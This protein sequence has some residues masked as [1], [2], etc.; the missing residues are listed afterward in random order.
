[1]KLIPLPFQED[2][3]IIPALPKALRRRFVGCRVIMP[4]YSE[5]G[6]NIGTRCLYRKSERS[7]FVASAVCGV[8]ELKNDGVIYYFWITSITSNAP[9]CTAFYDDAERYAFLP[10]RF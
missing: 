7:G 5:I 1:M 10:V 4:L 9:E 3:G 8:F 6:E 2:S